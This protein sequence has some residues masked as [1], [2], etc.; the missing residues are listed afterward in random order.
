ML[1]MALTRRGAGVLEARERD[2]PAVRAGEVLVRVGACGVCRTDLH[3][4]DDELPGIEVP[5]VPGHEIV[6]TIERMGG[7]VSGCREGDRVGIPWLGYTWARATTAREIARTSVVVPDSPVI[8]STVATR[9][10]PWPMPG[11]CSHCR[12]RTVMSMRLHSCV[13]G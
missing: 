13:P 10:T 12:T 6:G 8:R 2:V 4:V 7:G 1:S 11:T 3:V 5:R 9:S